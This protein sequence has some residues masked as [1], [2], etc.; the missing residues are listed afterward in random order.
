MKNKLLALALCAV[1]LGGCSGY[2]QPPEAFHESLLQPYTFETSDR[3]RVTVFG[4]P[5]LSNTYSIDQTGNMSVPLIGTLKAKGQTPAQLANTIEAKLRNGF[6]RE[7]DVSVEVAEYRPIFIMGEVRNAGQYA[8]IA[9]MTAQN[10]I[11]TAG[12]FTA[13]ANQLD[14]DITR[15]MNGEILQGRVPITDPLKPG[16]TLYIRERLF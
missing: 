12:G 4:Q 11:A 2:R 3:V 7:P 9:G 1:V 16:D 8:Y 5:E 6:I 14:V 10:A 15:Q 13:R